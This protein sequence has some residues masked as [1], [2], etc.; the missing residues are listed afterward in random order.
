MS[1]SPHRLENILGSSSAEPP[2]TFQSDAIFSIHYLAV[3][4]GTSRDVAGI[5]LGTGSAFERRR[6]M[7][8]RRAIAIAGLKCANSV[9]TNCWYIGSAHWA[10]RANMTSWPSFA[11]RHNLHHLWIV[12][13]HKSQNTPVPYP[14]MLHSEQKCAHFCFEWSIVGYGTGAFWNLW[15]RSVKGTDISSITST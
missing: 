11:N 12:Q 7:S 13:F 15:I 10:A 2:V 1:K 14:T 4:I 8:L 9:C 5:I 3:S 6:Y